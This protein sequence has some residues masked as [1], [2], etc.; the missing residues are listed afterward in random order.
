MTQKEIN[1][2][3]KQIGLGTDLERSK[4]INWDSNQNESN[5]FYFIQNTPGSTLIKEKNNA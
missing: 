2:I 4:Y 3:Y 1:K 5:E